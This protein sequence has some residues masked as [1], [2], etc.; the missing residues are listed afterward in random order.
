MT[1]VAM[2]QVEAELERMEEL[3]KHVHLEMATMRRRAEEAEA[4]DASIR[5][6]CG[7]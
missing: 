6:R 4:L 7:H 1:H 5:G 2:S 3:A